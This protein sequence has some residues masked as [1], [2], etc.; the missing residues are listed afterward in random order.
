MVSVMLGAALVPNMKV[1]AESMVTCVGIQ[2]RMDEADLNI[3]DTL[4]LGIQINYED[5]TSIP[6]RKSDET[7]IITSSKPS[8]VMVGSHGRVTAKA[9]GSATIT[10]RTEDGVHT[11]RCK[12][13]VKQP[14]LT[15]T[16]LTMY[17]EEV[18]WLY[19]RNG[20]GSIE[21][22]TS[23]PKIVKVSSK[24][25]ITGVAKGEATITA[26]RNRIR[27]T[28]NVKVKKV[29]LSDTNVALYEEQ[30]HKLEIKRTSKT[31]EWTSSNRNVATV[32]KQGNV[33][34]KAKGNVTITAKVGTKR[35]TCNVTVR[36][37]D[38][39][40]GKQTVTIESKGKYQFNITNRCKDFKQIKY[41]M[42]D[43]SIAEITI[44]KEKTTKGTIT[45][46]PKKAGK[47]DITLYRK[48]NPD[49]VKTLRVTI[50][51]SAV[52]GKPK[53]IVYMPSDTV[54]KMEI[55]SIYIQNKGSKKLTI[56]SV[57]YSY[58]HDYS[59]Y[60]RTMHLIDIGTLKRLNQTNISAHSA[61]SV[62]FQ[63]E[64]KKTW[65]DSKT[66]YHFFI[67]YDGLEYEVVVSNYL[68]MSIRLL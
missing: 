43:S 45:I 1:M 34:A 20:S 14:I 31:I 67:K 44:E 15:E 37:S 36:Q 26:I 25:K 42:L 32:S 53:F 56:Q 11:E 52:S 46:L 5:G 4:D 41:K 58:D 48:A 21:W 6:W 59:G 33:T 22:K 68:G 54:K 8:I 10:V 2:L 61:A 29:K 62:Y 51:A 39:L 23:N 9:P 27:M 16:A 13:T 49:D 18:S 65:Y 47:V 7:L 30:T 55:G 50:R 64:G 3:D 66:K 28:C 40:I 57:A 24:G 35:Y 38:L 19:V 60:D 12:I 17:E 63:V